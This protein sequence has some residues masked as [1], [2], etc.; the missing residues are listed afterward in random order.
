M[1]IRWDE[2]SGLPVNCR[3]QLPPLVSA[4]FTRIREA[5]AKDPAPA[6]MHRLRLETK[7]LRYT[8]ELFRP[9][10]GPGLETRLAA[11]RG[12]QQALGDLNDSVAAQRLLSKAMKRSAQRT[13]VHKF[14]EQRSAEQSAA[15]RKHW[16]EVFDAPGQ[17]TWWTGYLARNARKP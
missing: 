3:K 15:F 6:K 11:L 5:L 4:Y 10:Y 8:L 2:R 9:C 16:T 13:H 1:R 17:E 7:R 14:L 12:L